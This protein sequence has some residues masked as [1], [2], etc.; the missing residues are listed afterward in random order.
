MANR[1]KALSQDRE[2]KIANLFRGD[3]VNKFQQYSKNKT[4]W[5][6]D[7]FGVCVQ[8]HTLWRPVIF[9]TLFMRLSIVSSVKLLTLDRHT[10]SGGGLLASADFRNIAGQS[11]LFMVC[12]HSRF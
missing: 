7:I 2:P 12:R 5:C 10:S 3:S 1:A 4:G 9:S 11:M 8:T 6:F